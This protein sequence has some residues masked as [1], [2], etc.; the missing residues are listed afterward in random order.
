M[1]LHGDMHHVVRLIDYIQFTY[2]SESGVKKSAVE[3]D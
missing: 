2:F 1:K 3:D